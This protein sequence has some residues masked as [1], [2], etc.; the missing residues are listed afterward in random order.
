VSFFLRESD[1]VP[2]TPAKLEVLSVV[3]ASKPKAIRK[4]FV[5]R[6][7]RSAVGLPVSAFTAFLTTEWGLFL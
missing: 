4:K 3:E 6:I 5:K 2:F 1:S 7:R